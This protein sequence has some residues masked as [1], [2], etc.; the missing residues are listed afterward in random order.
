MYKI[1]SKKTLFLFVSVIVFAHVAIAQSYSLKKGN[2]LYSQKA[3]AE[4]IA[5]YEKV[6][7]KNSDNAEAIIKL[8]DCYRL[9]NNTSMAAKMYA[10]V[11]ELK[12]CQPIHKYYYGQTLMSMG[13]YSEAKRWMEQYDSDA[14]GTTFAKSIANIN[15][16][17]KDSDSYIISKLPFNSAQNDFSP[18]IY[19]QGIVFMSSREKETNMLLRTHAWTNKQFYSL[20]Y[21]D[22]SGT[23]YSEPKFFTKNISSKFNDGPICFSK[24]NNVA[25]FTRNNIEKGKVAKSAEG[26]VKLK[27]FS[28]K[29]IEDKEG[30]TV[31]ENSIPFAYNSNEY[32]CAHPAISNDGTKLFFTSDM[33]GG[34]GG[35]DLYVCTKEGEGWSKPTNLG[36][37]INTK[38]DEVFPFI[39]SD[40]TLFFSSN[41]R[42]GIGGLDIFYTMYRFG[43]ISSVINM[44][45]PINSSGDDF[46]L[47]IN[48]DNKTGYFSSNRQNLD[49]N[50]D[51]YSFIKLK[52]KFSIVVVDEKTTLNIKSSMVKIK[53]MVTGRI[54]EKQL[55]N[56][57]LE[58]D[59]FPNRKYEVEGIAD[60]YKNNTIAI[61]TNPSNPNIEVRLAKA[62]VLDLNVLVLNNFKE[63]S[64]VA[65]AQVSIIGSDGK[66]VLVATNEQGKIISIPLVGE[67]LYSLTASLNGKTSDKAIVSTEG[68][69]ETKT[70]EQTLYLENIGAVCLSGAVRDKMNGLIPLGG[71]K[72]IVTDPLTNE[73]VYETVLDKDGK[74]KT[75]Q[76]ET[77]KVYKVTAIKSGYFT[78]SEEVSTL[79][80]KKLALKQ[81]LLFEKNVDVERIIVG[82]SIKIDNIY[83]DL[84]KWNI[85]KDAAKE[86]D[87]IVR[88]LK[89]N[90]DIVIELGSHTDCRS[91]SKSN[92]DLSDKRAKSS[93]QYIV[94]HAIEAVRITGK[95]YGETQ[96]VNK[97][98]CEGPKKVPCTE[99][100][101]QANRR[102]EFKVVGFLK[103]GVIIYE[104]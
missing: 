52:E 84:G 101:H 73:K 72:L 31:F 3:Y 37:N 99:K 57:V 64:P 16:F 68:A 18:T 93:A 27:I 43:E 98:E 77:N 2:K 14:R 96:L 71:A 30:K 25:Y 8:A 103:D 36:D 20:Y 102:T 67:N 89:E 70:Y 55:D 32:S 34:F 10:K 69:K 90:D 41:G 61:I 87:K 65:N 19:K 60:T 21:T 58:I 45:A 104:K 22:K 5:S 80:K 13:N 35:M 47:T 100:E 38:G 44:G 79:D 88:L 49:L 40:G 62:M 86:L 74:Y 39:H 26:V 94:D 81:T 1:V 24:N 29:I 12:E 76:L 82:R 92:L 50:D 97:C 23:N 75:C 11:V 63:K 91:P 78:T 46:S 66:S 42:E 85:R 7:I 9:T 33:P 48:A 15:Q 51:I 17:F 28:A 6:L 53:D 56:G 54:I 59:L 83:F 4:A 95:G